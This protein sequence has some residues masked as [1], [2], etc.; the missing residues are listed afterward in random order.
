MGDAEGDRNLAPL[1][2]APGLSSPRPLAPR[3][4]GSLGLSFSLWWVRGRGPDTLH[5]PISGNK[6]AE[7]HL[8]SSGERAHCKTAVRKQYRVGAGG[9]G[10]PGMLGNKGA[11]LSS[12]RAFGAREGI[13]ERRKMVR[14]CAGRKRSQ[15]TD[16]VA[17]VSGDTLE[18]SKTPVPSS[19]ENK[20]KERQE[21][22]QP[23]LQARTVHC[24]E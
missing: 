7:D 19:G 6:K 13:L 21:C 1:P 12:C 14:S 16:L 18:F 8:L 23:G 22:H 4:P 10:I 15:G 11:F 3:R 2:P 5:F 9:G 20:E 24:R 17:L